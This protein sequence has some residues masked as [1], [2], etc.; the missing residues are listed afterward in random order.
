MTPACGDGADA[1][2]AWLGFVGG[3]IRNGLESLSVL[4]ARALWIV[5]VLQTCS[6]FPCAG[7]WGLGG[8]ERGEGVVWGIPDLP[9]WSVMRLAEEE[10]DDRGEGRERMDVT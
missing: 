8:L 9:F 2:E 1:H 5:L 4:Q 3:L 7:R 10:A 6:G